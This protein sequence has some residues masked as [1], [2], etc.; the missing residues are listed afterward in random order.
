AD[1]GRQ[2][3]VRWRGDGR[4]PD[5]DAAVSLFVWSTLL[6]IPVVIS[7]VYW[8]ATAAMM[9]RFFRARPPRNSRSLPAVALL[10][11]LS[12]LHQNLFRVFSPACRQDYPEDEVIFSVQDS[13]DPALPLLERIRDESPSVPVRIVVDTDSAGP[14]GRLSNILNATRHATGEVLVYSDSD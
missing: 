6:L 3:S 4:A 2:R 1:Q 13:D 5:P 10:N 12:R 9:L 7:C 11:P 8:I 14:N